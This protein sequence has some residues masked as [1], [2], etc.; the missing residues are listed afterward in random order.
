MKKIFSILALAIAALVGL[1][2]CE[3]NDVMIPAAELPSEVISFLDTHFSGIEVRSVIKDYD[4]SSY[5]FEVYLSDGTQL[6]LSRRGEWR[7]V[8]NHLSGVPHSVVPNKIL[9]YVEANYPDQMIVGIERDRE[10][11]VDLKS[12]M[13]LVFNLS[14]DF[15][16]F[17][18]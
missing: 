5:E 6:E 2:S 11:D 18:Y 15:V 12:G 8:K 13:E 4:N 7:N 16:R 9:T 14:E 10:I 17:D 3:K 1:Q